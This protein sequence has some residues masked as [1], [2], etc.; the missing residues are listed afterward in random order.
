LAEKYTE[1]RTDRNSF[2][3]ETKEPDFEMG[4]TR[5]YGRRMSP[6]IAAVGGVEFGPRK[7]PAKGAICLVCTEY[8]RSRKL[9]WERKASVGVLS[10]GGSCAVTFDKA[11]GALETGKINGKMQKGGT[12]EYSR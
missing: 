10:N 3:K 9:N 5:G 7:A 2:E 1:W 11:G 12:K 6:V 4:G 8:A